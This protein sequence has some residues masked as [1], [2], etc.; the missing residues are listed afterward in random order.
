MKKQVTFQLSE[1]QEQ[2]QQRLEVRAF[3]FKQHI[4]PL[5]HSS[6]EANPFY[7]ACPYQPAI[8][9]ALLAYVAKDYR[10]YH[11]VYDRLDREELKAKF[12]QGV[13]RFFAAKM[14]LPV[15]RKAELAQQKLKQ[16]E[17]TCLAYQTYLATSIIKL[18]RTLPKQA[19]ALYCDEHQQ[20]NIEQLCEK[21]KSGHTLLGW[22][23]SQNMDLHSTETH[24]K[25]HE[26]IK[27]YN[28]VKALQTLLTTA[29]PTPTK[30][31]NQFKTAFHQ[32]ETQATLKAHRDSKSL[33]FIKTVGHILT[34]GLVSYWQKKTFAFWKPHGEVMT[35]QL[36]KTLA[37]NTVATVLQR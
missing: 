26:T 33:Q 14:H 28:T 24:P 25:L 21:A 27:K 6:I 16:L 23:L 19:Y 17:Q 20:L 30:Q 31:L 12:T 37:A 4:L 22:E 3:D 18:A 1:A 10:A 11:D 35:Q 13:S 8:G 36:E 15:L 2:K 7:Q 29:E 34:L 5:I 9:R 32:L